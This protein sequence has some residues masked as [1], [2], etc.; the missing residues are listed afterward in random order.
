M[1]G[2]ILGGVSVLASL[3]GGAQSARANRAVDNQ[4]A[5]QKSELQTW[6]DKEYNQNY[7]ES[8][9]AQSTLQLLRNQM[10][11]RMKA[12]DQSNAIRGASDEARIATADKLG[13]GY[14][15]AATQ[16][17]GYGTRKQDYTNRLYQSLKAGQDAQQM[18]NLQSK[19]A[20]WTNFMGNAINAGIG[21]AQAGDSFTSLEDIWKVGKAKRAVTAAAPL[22]AG[23]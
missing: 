18:Q 22:I 9:E 13:Q 11:Q 3:F 20:N 8:S 1:I 19:A 14:S 23:F 6:Y 16:L 12:V 7:L 17:A 4:L 5:K 10:G 2:E 15:N 21:A